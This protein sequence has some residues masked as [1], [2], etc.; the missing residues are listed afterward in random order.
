MHS[1]KLST[2]FA[3]TRMRGRS[4]QR[5]TCSAKWPP[6]ATDCAIRDAM[7]SS[8]QRFILYGYVYNARCHV[9]IS[10]RAELKLD[11][12]DLLSGN[13]PF[14]AALHQRSWRL[15]EATGITSRDLIPQRNLSQSS[16][17]LVSNSRAPDLEAVARALQLHALAAIVSRGVRQNH[18]FSLFANDEQ[19]MRRVAPPAS[20]TPRTPATK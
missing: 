11:I 13:S 18:S 4:G 6:R 14:P 12:E 19:Q 2:S 9:Q 15:M 5:S 16:E 20:Q 1:A 3:F 7:L 17:F 10:D 8:G